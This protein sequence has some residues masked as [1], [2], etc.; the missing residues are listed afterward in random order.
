MTIA[1]IRH[2]PRVRLLLAP[3]TATGCMTSDD[4]CYY[5]VRGTR[6]IATSAHNSDGLSDISRSLLLP[7]IVATGDMT[8]ENHCYYWARGTCTVVTGG[9]NI[10]MMYGIR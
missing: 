3:T 7:P 2:V 4:R 8:S 10:D 1:T 9:H 5:G 6:A